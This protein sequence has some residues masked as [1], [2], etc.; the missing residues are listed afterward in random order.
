MSKSVYVAPTQA[1]YTSFGYILSV[2]T[3]KHHTALQIGRTLLL[4]Q[5]WP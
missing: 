3:T 1:Q 5:P 4:L 2:L